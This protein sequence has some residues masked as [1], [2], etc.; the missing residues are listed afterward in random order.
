MRSASMRRGPPQ[1]E[2]EHRPTIRPTEAEELRRPWARTPAASLEILPGG[3]GWGAG[4]GGGG[5]GGDL[6]LGHAR[7]RPP[8]FLPRRVGGEGAG[9]ARPPPA[10]PPR[11]DPG[12]A[13][14]GRRVLL[15]R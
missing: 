14:R 11:R 2:R 4:P 8:G 1:T 7:G 15:V 6:A 12:R 5:A 9:A 13:L 10:V 3:A